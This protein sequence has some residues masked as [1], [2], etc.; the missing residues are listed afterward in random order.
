MKE[1]SNNNELENNKEGAQELE[2]LLYYFPQPQP[3]P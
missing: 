2:P 3:Q 1:S